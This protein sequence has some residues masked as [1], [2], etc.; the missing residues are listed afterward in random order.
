MP[1]VDRVSSTSSSLTVNWFSDGYDV[2]LT[3]I[4]KEDRK[5]EGALMD[6]FITK[7]EQVV[8]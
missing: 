4:K 3:I 1:K 2:Y 6:M 5:V 7:F 8:E